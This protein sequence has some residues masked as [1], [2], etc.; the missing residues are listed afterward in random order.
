MTEILERHLGR[1]SKPEARKKLETEKPKTVPK[2]PITKS[3]YMLYTEQLQSDLKADPDF[4]QSSLVELSTIIGKRWGSLSELERAIWNDRALKLNIKPS[5]VEAV[6]P[7]PVPPPVNPPVKRNKV[8]L[9]DLFDMSD[10]ELPKKR[11]AEGESK[12][13][14]K[15]RN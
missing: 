2:K 1:P 7:Q 12:A 4:A 15:Y 3:G 13:A 10:S 5:S 9:S 14:S 8:S 11:G 6:H